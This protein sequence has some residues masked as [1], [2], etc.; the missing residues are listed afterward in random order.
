M[1]PL[2]TIGM[3]HFQDFDGVYFT[4]QALKMYHRKRLKDIELIVVDNSGGPH[5][6]AVE[7]LVTHFSHLFAA[8]RY[9]PFMENV[10]TTQSRE[11][12]FQE[13]SGR[14]VLC[15]DCHV[16]IEPNGIDELLRYYESNPT[17]NDIISGPIVFDDMQSY[18]THFD[19]KWRSEM[20]GVWG[21][22]WRGPGP[23]DKCFSVYVPEGANSTTLVSYHDLMTF[24][25]IT[26]YNGKP[27]PTATASTHVEVLSAAGFIRPGALATDAPFEIPAMGLGLFSMRRMAWP[28]FNKHMRGFGGEEGYIHCKVRQLGGRAIC[29]PPLRWNHRFP[30]P[31]G[32]TYPISRF[33]KIRNAVLT[34][35][36]LG[37]PLYPIKKHFVID[38]PLMSPHEWE[39]LVA[40]PINATY[41]KVKRVGSDGR[42]QMTH[43]PRTLGELYTWTR[44]QPRDLDQHLETLSRL[45][46]DCDT[47]VEISK[48]RESSV[49]LLY[50]RPNKLISYQEERN[51][52][53]LRVHAHTLAAKASVDWQVIPRDGLGHDVPIPQCEL[54]FIDD[55]HNAR[56]LSAQLA[57]H[58]KQVVGYIVL[59]D[60]VYHGRVGD[61]GQEGL[62]DA[63]RNFVQDNPE[64]YVL[65]HHETQYGLTV[66]CNLDSLRSQQI[67]P[68]WPIGRGAGTELHRIL[69]SMGFHTT[70]NC[71]C[72]QRL[73]EMDQRGL[74]WCR[75][76][77]TTIIDWLEEEAQAPERKAAGLLF[78]RAAAW[79]LVKRAISSAAKDP[80][81]RK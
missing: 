76:N 1:R 63:L 29:L 34:W 35:N 71:K 40:D 81:S 64:W 36:E 15:M 32:I 25:V 48:R 9:I 78:S 41:I 2:L 5:G 11:R 72:R 10:G 45:A 6:Q 68:P 54:L 57:L 74:E 8:A 55:R 12:V 62:F 70:P 56:A 22:A 28:G 69:G 60:T 67:P 4:I 33:D 52:E 24:E 21:Q 19:L 46:K 7:A 42:A 27:L 20:W 49:A 38:N 58:A 79:V 17:T 50:A 16:L 26:T 61:D 75:S 65:E 30:R 53:L 14:F 3:A 51:D 37:F 23:E 80:L 18:S 31:N 77:V 59:H 44:A 66:L 39:Q 43:E 47:I 73:E 13:A